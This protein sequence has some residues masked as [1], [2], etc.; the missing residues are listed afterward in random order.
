M[1]I[2][3][4][5][6]KEQEVMNSSASKVDEAKEHESLYH[7]ETKNFLQS[8]GRKIDGIINQHHVVNKQHGDIG[9]LAEEI[10]G[11]MSDM[12][13]IAGTTN[14]YTNKLCSEGKVLISTTESTVIKSQEGRQAI[15]GM[16]DIIN[17]L[18]E[19]NKKTYESINELLSRFSRINEVTQLINNIAN[20]TNLLALNAAIEAARAGENGK[21]FAV[22]ADEVKK[23]AEMT[24]NSTKDITTLIKDIEIETKKV[25]DNSNKNTEIIN[26]GVSISNNAIEKV[27]ESLASFEYVGTGV[28]G[29]MDTLTNQKE[30]ID[31]M[32]KKIG[33]VDDVLQVVNRALGQHITEAEKVDIQL[34][35]SVKELSAKTNN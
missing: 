9:K 6:V 11:L 2:F 10:E 30:Q 29:V 27:D 13:G 5:K 25:L 28:S 24:A 26:K 17:S 35:E 14:T 3:K 34:V 1:G 31:L 19:E 23:L 4:K 12:T 8:M 7:S 18:A 20:Q 16:I 21:G 22:V 33:K 32:M 15:E